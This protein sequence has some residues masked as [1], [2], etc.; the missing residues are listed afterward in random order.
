MCVFASQ[1]VCLSGCL[2]ISVHVCDSDFSS[3]FQSISRSVG[4]FVSR[5]VFLL[6]SQFVHLSVCQSVS[7]SVIPISVLTFSLPADQSVCL[8]AGL[9]VC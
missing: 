8:S 6:V 2:S 7:M 1:I 3:D 5:S 9:C 4:V